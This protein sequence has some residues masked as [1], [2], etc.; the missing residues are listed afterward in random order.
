MAKSSYK[1]IN[2]GANAEHVSFLSILCFQWINAVLK[3]G[4]ERVIEKSDC[5]PLAKENTTCS[6]I[7]LLQT[8][9]NEE[10]TKCKRNAKNPKLWKSVLKILLVKDGMTLISC[11]ILYK[12]CR[13]L[14]PLLLV[15]LMVSLMIPERQDNY[16]RYGCALAIGINA[17]IGRLCAHQFSYRCDVLGIRI[18]SA[19]KGLVY[20]KVSRKCQN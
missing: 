14:Q 18:S 1:K 12:L 9:W 8:K 20:L 4:N 15:Y 19:L 7:E 2:N 13:I 5:L 10:T 3:R 11:G 17:V 6:V 16:L